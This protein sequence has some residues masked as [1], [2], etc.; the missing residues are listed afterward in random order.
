[1]A[2]KATGGLF[3]YDMVSREE[4]Q[5]SLAGL[6]TPQWPIHGDVS[7]GGKRLAVDVRDSVWLTSRVAIYDTS[8]GR[9]TPESPT[10]PD[11]RE[12]WGTSQSEVN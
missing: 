6:V 9:L 1:M 10:L 11:G 5:V 4:H 3:R 12:L 8:T 2:L 7:P